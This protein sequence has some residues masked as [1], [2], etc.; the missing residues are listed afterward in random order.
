MSDT[1]EKKL[2]LG[3]S[4]Y[5]EMWGADQWR[6]DVERMAEVGFNLM[7]CF[8]FAWHRLEP[9]PGRYEFDWAIEVL[10]LMHE[11]GIACMVGTPTAAPPAWLTSAHP[12]VLGTSALGKRKGNGKRKHYNHHSRVYREHARRITEEFVHRFGQHPALHSWQIDNEMSGFDYDEETRAAFHDWLAKRFT[13]VDRMNSTWGLDFSSQAYEAFSQVPLVVSNVGSI[14]M[15]ERHHPSL[16]LA[17][18][19]FQNEAWTRFIEEQVQIIRA[20]SDRPISTNMTGLVGAMDW[21]S[22]N[23]CLDRVGASIYADLKHYHYNVPRLDR[24]RSEKEAPFWLLE[25]APN[26]SGGGPI[27]NIHQ[28]EQGVEAMTW[29]NVLSG[30]E[31]CLYWQWRSHWAGQEMQ[32]GTCVDACGQWRPG[33]SAWR[34]LGRAFS[35][36]GAWLSE[37]PPLPS[38][39]ALVMS[40]R[41]SWAFN[42]DPIEDD[43]HYESV[44]RDHYHA[45]LRDQHIHRD[46]IG[47]GADISP[48][49][50]LLMPQIPMVPEERVEELKAWVEAG[51]RLLLGPLTGYRTTDFTAHIDRP[52][53]SLEA[54]M[55]ARMVA[56]APTRDIEDR[57]RL[58]YA[59]GRSGKVKL[60]NDAFELEGGAA[61]ASYNGGWCDGHVAIVDHRLGKGRVITLG[62][63]VEVSD[64]LSLVSLLMEE[65]G[66]EPLARGDAGVL[67]IPRGKKDEGVSGYGVVNYTREKKRI[68]LPQSGRDRFTGRRVGADLELEPLEVLLIES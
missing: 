57:V 56:Q 3:A 28:C 17:I 22:H 63:K 31:M 13:T 33:K 4:W 64:Y 6:A 25:T 37:N 62:T 30:A 54:L 29:M 60:W 61:I 32:H 7:R 36:H 20:K 45:S 55:G 18:A 35:E 8:E 5:P 26:W 14:A 11:H 47:D 66:I 51:G 58:E 43:N 19:E 46:V 21:F 59:D 50:I 40:N 41:A 42:I 1:K 12:E 24:M 67:V 16:I 2:W 65:I 27:W 49:G 9:S 53:G 34:R 10:D 15:P 48:Y 23:Q 38:P 44:W 39:L 52:H 68:T